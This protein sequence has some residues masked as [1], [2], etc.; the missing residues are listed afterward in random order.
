MPS[1]RIDLIQP[2]MTAICNRHQSHARIESVLE[3]GVGWGKYGVLLREYLSMQDIMKEDNFWNLRL[4]SVEVC[5]QYLTGF[6]SS[7]YTHMYPVDIREF[8]KDIEIWSGIWT[9]DLV[10]LIEVL[11]HMPKEDGH[12]VIKTL[13]DYA[14][15]IVISTPKRLVRQ[16]VEFY[17]EQ[18][19]HVSLWNI[20]DFKQY[21]ID[22]IL[23]DGDERG[24][25]ALVLR[26]GLWKERPPK[27]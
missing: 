26:G 24:T 20:E 5:P 10:L 27:R 6:K 25:L 12:L 18:E 21:S 1:S 14:H 9:W 2:I 8:C 15:W 16:P 7:L 23:V 4:D 3:V 22:E 19:Q 13:L 17:H 11:E